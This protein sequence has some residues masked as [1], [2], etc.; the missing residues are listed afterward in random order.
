[1]IDLIQFK[2][3]SGIAVCVPTLERGNEWI[4]AL[5]AK[6]QCIHLLPADQV[7]EYVHDLFYLV[8]DLAMSFGVF[9]KYFLRSLTIKFYSLKKVILVNIRLTPS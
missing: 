3:A 4:I 5:Q 1:V 9:F 8:V 7:L 2:G 6:G